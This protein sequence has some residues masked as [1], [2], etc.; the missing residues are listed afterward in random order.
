MNEGIQQQAGYFSPKV[1]KELSTICENELEN[2]TYG[3]V[4]HA[5]AGAHGLHA[6]NSVQGIIPPYLDEYVTVTPY[7]NYVFIIQFI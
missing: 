2:G 1:H 4:T 3:V 5:V 7:Y 6:R